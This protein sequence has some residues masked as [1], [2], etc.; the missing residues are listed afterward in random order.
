M[1]TRLFCLRNS[2]R[3]WRAQ[4]RD[5]IYQAAR[6]SVSLR[7]WG[8]KLSC[9]SR[10]PFS[11]I[12]EQ[13][14]IRSTSILPAVDTSPYVERQPSAGCIFAERICATGAEVSPKIKVPRLELAS[15]G[16][17]SFENSRFNFRSVSRVCAPAQSAREI[18][19]DETR[20][21]RHACVFIARK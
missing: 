1:W 14:S 19:R 18:R 15:P 7:L 8:R 2:P 17:A 4:Y 11:R 6:G 13:T 5:A 3:D 21:F 10:L 12:N 16:G 9:F 20:S